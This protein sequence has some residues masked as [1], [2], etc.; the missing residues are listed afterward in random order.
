MS[1][2]YGGPQAQ[3]GE[4]TCPLFHSR[5]EQSQISSLHWCDSRAHA[6]PFAMARLW[7]QGVQPTWNLGLRELELEGSLAK[8]KQSFL[9]QKNGNYHFLEAGPSPSCPVASG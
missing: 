2:S 5:Q 6:M 7:P 9:C 4:V 3:R 8:L 1:L